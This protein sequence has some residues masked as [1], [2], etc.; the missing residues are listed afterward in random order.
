MF[1]NLSHRKKKFILILGILILALLAI[2]AFL[3]FSRIERAHDAIPE[4]A[5]SAP[6]RVNTPRPSGKAA[7]GDGEGEEL[8]TIYY[9]GR[10]YLYN[11]SLSTLLILGIDDVQLTETAASRNSSQADMILLAVFDPGRES[12]TLLQLNRDTMCEVPVLDYN[13][14]FVRYQVE[15]LALAHTY[16]SGME[17]SCENT[18][19]AVSRF[20]YGA[21]IDNYFAFTMDAIPILNDLVGGVTVTVEDDFSGVDPTLVKGNAVKLTAEN[22]EHFVRA[23]SSMAEDP[24]NINRMKRQRAYLTGLGE[25]LKR[26]MSEDASFVIE[27]YSALSGSLVTDCSVDQMSAYGER[28]SGYALSGIVTPEGEAVGGEKFMEYYADEEALRQLVLD[29]FYLPAGE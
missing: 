19:E 17:K 21:E 14:K 11:D 26:T 4:G 13:G 7:P 3:F 6:N 29:V 2:A 22:V 18:V 23:R 20:L 16:G 12:C 27:A 1:E 9:N 8:P 5:G 28:F 25:E 15:Q 10:E 24:T